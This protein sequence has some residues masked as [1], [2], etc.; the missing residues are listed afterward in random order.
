MN[1]KILTGVSRSSHRSQAARLRVHLA[2]LKNFGIPD[3]QDVGDYALNPL[4]P[5][6][7][8]IEAWEAAQAHANFFVKAMADR[9]VTED[10]YYD[11]CE[12]AS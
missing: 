3:D 2:E 4:V 11:E 7:L 10:G 1:I 5:Q 8:G 9:G 6:G 12:A